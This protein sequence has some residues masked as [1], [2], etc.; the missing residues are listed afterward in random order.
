MQIGVDSFA[1]ATIDR[2][3]GE[4]LV[5]LDLA[6]VEILGRELVAPEAKK[7]SDDRG[8]FRPEGRRHMSVRRRG[9][10]ALDRL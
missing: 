6:A 10:I 4:V 8:R 9:Q 7:S 5:P 3:T 1:A 2:A